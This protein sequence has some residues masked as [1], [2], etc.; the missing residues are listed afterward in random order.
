MSRE[1][2]KP[3][4]RREAQASNPLADSQTQTDALEEVS[5]IK[6]LIKENAVDETIDTREDEH[7]GWM[8]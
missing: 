2:W 4:E 1:R 6:E 3:N 5:D 8:W 7:S